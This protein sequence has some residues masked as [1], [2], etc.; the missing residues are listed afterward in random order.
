MT[1]I[2]Q[3]ILY[4]VMGCLGIE[5]SGEGA[6]SEG[7]EL[8]ESAIEKKGNVAIALPGFRHVRWNYRFMLPTSSLTALTELSN[9]ACSSSLSLNSMIFSM[10][11][12]PRTQGTPT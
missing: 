1:T 6:G 8:I 12:A 11:F 4:T 3:K 2:C 7:P 10:P 9:M 5:Q